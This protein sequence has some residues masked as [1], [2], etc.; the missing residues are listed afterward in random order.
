MHVKNLSEV[1]LNR[2]HISTKEAA[3]ILLVKPQTMRKSHC[4]YGEYAGIRPTRLASRKLAWPVDGIE[5]AL[6]H[7][8]A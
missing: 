8:A 6:M 7:G 2:T 4:I 5:R 3:A 1:C